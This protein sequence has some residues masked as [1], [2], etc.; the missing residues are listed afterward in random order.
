MKTG[1]T[2]LG[3]PP[4]WRA[5][6]FICI[7]SVI[8]LLIVVAT[9]IR[10]PSVAYAD[11]NGLYAV[12][13]DPIQEGNSARMGIRRSGHKVL[14]ATVFTDSYSYSADS[15]DYTEYHGVRFKQS[16][17]RTLWIPIE[18]TE[19]S[20]PERDETFSI[21]FWDDNDFYSCVVTIED[22]DMPEIISVDLASNPI[23]DWAYRADDTIDVVVTFDANV[24]V[25]GI[26]LLA[27]YLR[28]NGTNTWRGASYHQGS[29]TRELVFRYRVQPQDL[30]SEGV[31]VGAAATGDDRTPAYG[32]VGAINAQGTDAPVAYTHA[33]I[34]RDWRQRVDGR[35]YVQSI[36]TISSPEA[37]G[38][39][40]RAGENIELAFTFNTHVVVEGEVSV[41]LRLGYDGYHIE[42]TNRHAQYHRGSGTDTLV[43]RYTVRQGDMDPN[44]IIVAMGTGITGFGGSGT[45]KAEG[46]DV[47][48]N[49]WYLGTSWQTGHKVD[50][51]PPIASS[52][53]IT[54]VPTNA[55]AYA[56]GETVSVEVAFSE[57][58]T[59]S[60][61]PYLELN[62]G[63]LTR[64]AALAT[65]EW[66]SDKLVFEYEVQGADSDNDGISI[67]A[68][69]LRL[70]DGA[71][72]DRAGN[73]ANVSHPVIPASP[74]HRVAT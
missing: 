74:T 19:D 2:V 47:E 69:S 4:P 52:L 43:F 24:E 68:N 70:Y 59:A 18:T 26:P 14:S 37:G 32:F 56:A 25:E 3:R 9:P 22:D 72:H 62:V 50:T 35:P 29:G 65:H 20:R 51:A 36:Q 31:S 6:I 1:I 57:W 13:P 34:E 49:P 27:L 60:G 15:D 41:D 33:G 61:T 38:P 40:Y 44:G 23:D 55:E 5:A 7:A 46:T 67:D 63:G 71:I 12:C 21:G 8:A 64:R 39:T 45:I 10:G 73:N 42:G 48:R 30:G 11:H 66:P 16:Q 53:T 54:S 17:G 28:E 58:V